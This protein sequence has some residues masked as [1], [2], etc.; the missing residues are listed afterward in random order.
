MDVFLDFLSTTPG[1]ISVV[2]AVL[3]IIGIG[4][5]ISK[6]RKPEL[7]PAEPKRE[8]ERSEGAPE[9]TAGEPETA[10]P[11]PA[12]EGAVEPSEGEVAPAGEEDQ[13]LEPD[14]TDTTDQVEA[15]PEEAELEEGST[16][17]AEP[18]IEEQLDEPES[19]PSRMQRLRSRLA[20]SGRIGSALLA[21]LSRGDLSEE[22][23]EDLEDTLLMADLG[24]DATEEVMENLRTQVKVHDTSDP[25]QVRE[26]LRQ[27]LLKVVNPDMD[28]SLNLDRVDTEEGHNPAVVLMVGVN[29][30]GKTTT[31]GKLARL[32]V[33]EDKSVI[34]GAAD[35]FRAAAAEQLTTWGNRVGVETIA[36]DV[37][38]AD[39]A[40]VA[41][42]AVKTGRE[43][44]V[45]IVLVDTAG[46]LQNKSTLMDE[47][48]K[49]KRVMEKQ[50]PIA[51]TL[52]VLDATTGQN[53]LRQAEVFAQVVDVTG[54]VLT[55]L[56]G[57]AK[58]GI[59]VSVQRQLGV[60]VKLV[61][62]GEGADDL[63]PFNPVDFVNAI[64]G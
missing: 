48:G 60:P 63:A 64:V 20:G 26:L 23:W 3:A 16:L 27:E 62:L 54:V 59:V 34:L 36:S 29:G 49:V 24:L 43:Q 28:R 12:P 5:G 18:D 25:E 11:A 14:H 15:G 37:E 45:D 35:T 32:L 33:A 8:I 52:L 53:G 22:D 2:I 42:D 30:T 9:Q 21:I 39:P 50:C 7:P 31:V 6:S 40:S 17:E 4:V 10:E 44:G 41:F 13:P 57:S 19:A 56:D 1:I 55:K 46:R 47:L 38:G 51:E 58:G 61:G